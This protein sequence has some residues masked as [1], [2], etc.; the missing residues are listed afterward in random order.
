MEL[1]LYSKKKK[2][3]TSPE[4]LQ[5]LENLQQLM[6]ILADRDQLRFA[7]EVRFDS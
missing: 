5:C 7:R 2:T 1:L 6:E 4:C 3:K